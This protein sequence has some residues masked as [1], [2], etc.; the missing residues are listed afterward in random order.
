MN[1]KKDDFSGLC[2]NKC[3]V[4]VLETKDKWFGVTCKENKDAVARSFKKLIEDGVYR[5]ELSHRYICIHT[6]IASRSAFKC[7]AFCRLWE[8]DWEKCR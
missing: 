6:Y 3:S 1:F 2:A 5:E 7:N 4:K 8:A